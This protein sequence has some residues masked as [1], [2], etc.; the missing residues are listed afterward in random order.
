M[1]RSIQN[2][3][4][5]GLAALLWL[6]AGIS[7]GQDI[8]NSAFTVGTTIRDSSGQGWAYITW[9]APDAE[10]LRNRDFAVYR[11][12]GAAP[13]EKLSIAR[14]TTD[15]AL[16]ET[17]LERSTHVGQDL[18]K[19]GD[20]IDS[21]F[22]DLVTGGPQWTL[23]QK[24]S[25]I[26]SSSLN[27]PEASDHLTMLARVFPAVNLCMGNA[28]IDALND[29]A[30]KTYEIRDFDVAA[31]RDLSVIGQVSLTNGQVVKLTAPGAP[32]AIQDRSP[33]GNL[34]AKL[35]WAT[36]NELRRLGPLT[37]G[38]NVFRFDAQ[39]AETNGYNYVAPDDIDALLISNPTKVKKINRVLAHALVDYSDSDYN[40]I[41]TDLYWTLLGRLPDG[42]GLAYWVGQL[43]AGKTPSW[44]REQISLSDEYRDVWSGTNGVP[45]Q[46]SG[47]NAS[48]TVEG[49]SV[50]SPTDKEFFVADDNGAFE[51][52]GVPFS[53]CDRFYYFVAAVDVLGRNG[54]LSPGSEV[55]ICDQMEP[56]V[57]RGLKVENQYT[58]T[59]NDSQ[60]LKVIWDQVPG[61]G[62]TQVANYYVYRWT[63]PGE[64]LSNALNPRIRPIAGPIAH[65][66][67]AEQNFYVDDKTGSPSMPTFAGTT[68]WY[69]VV[70][71]D[72]AQCGSCLGNRSGHSPP[73]FGVLRDRVGPEPASNF[74]VRI[75]C[76][77]PSVK[78]T[79]TFRIAAA[80]PGSGVQGWLEIPNL[81]ALVTA[82]DACSAVESITQVP[83][84]GTRVG[85]TN[86]QSITVT[87]RDTASN[88]VSRT[89][90]VSVTNTSLPRHDNFRFECERN[91]AGIQWAEFF[92]KQGTNTTLI[93]MG[94]RYFEPDTDK[95]FVT[96]EEMP[97]VATNV[98]VAVL[99]RVG[100]FSG[101][102]TPLSECRYN[103][104]TPPYGTI[105]VIR[106]VATIS[107]SDET[108]SDAC[109]T[110][111]TVD[112]GSTAINPVELRVTPTETTREWKVYRRVDDQPKT[113]VAQGLVTFTNA[114]A[115]DIVWKDSSPPV[116]GGTV[117]YFM[118]LFDEHGNPGPM[119]RLDCITMQAVPGIST[120]A[121]G[122][123]VMPAPML[124]AVDP[125]GS[126][127]SPEM[128]L[129]WFCEPDGVDHFNIWISS[130]PDGLPSPYSDRLS[131]N[132]APPD[133][134]REVTIGDERKLLRFDKFATRR[135]G[136]D[137]I[138]QQPMFFLKIPAELDKS[139]TLAI[140]AVDS[141]G[142][143]SRLSNAQRIQ[144]G[145]TIAAT[146][147]L[148]ANDVPWPARPWRKVTNSGYVNKCVAKQ[149]SIPG[150]G[151]QGVGVRIGEVGI[152]RTACANGSDADPFFLPGPLAPAEHVYF[153]ELDSG[154]R[155]MPFMLYRYQVANPKGLT[156]ASGDIVQVSP[157]MEEIAY[158]PGFS[159]RLG[160]QGNFVK[161][162][163]FAVLP[164]DVD[165]L[166]ETTGL[167]AKQPAC[168]RTLP[169]LSYK[170]IF[171]DCNGPVTKFQDPPA[172]TVMGIGTNPVTI[173]ARDSFGNLSTNAYRTT[174]V[175]PE[176][177]VNTP[178]NHEIYVLDTQPVLVGAK[179]RYLVVLF[180]ALHEIDQ[181]IPVDEVEISPVP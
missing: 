106:F 110:H 158:A 159:Q 172:G 69:T 72:N 160:L 134:R 142:A 161:D 96:Y 128:S 136:S 107:F 45:P 33:K 174:F 100:T 153:S 97:L 122:T 112:P 51:A 80:S 2:V 7:F 144:F 148:A 14:M 102:E 78:Y 16:I 167:Y 90:S 76:D 12:S 164:E 147:G 18:V 85:G 166:D 52:G 42:D 117:C 168:F 94:R 180:N 109:S 55:R 57:P 77:S 59:T 15:P 34:V 70:A 154:K 41:V 10:P 165:V 150:T 125:A 27:D 178:K 62:A 149:I 32:F 6:A 38:F 79:N 4:G 141:S 179:Y 81:A 108:Q 50:T 113:L 61:T 1:K 116:N 133:E 132:L 177:P 130:D 73:G 64:A 53:G 29:G 131:T 83:V 35:R 114:T 82:T 181:V 17:L 23:A 86:S 111:V 175:V 170:A 138:G 40:Q 87:A 74:A 43:N 11:K 84:P 36:P 20:V 68:V 126:D 99:C 92:I 105:Q 151:F 3:T 25:A 37:T 155:I 30:L 120:D 176:P 65:I 171:E 19:L 119:T 89:V 146:N 129:V 56:P 169:D 66:P 115:Q 67:G 152:Q 28:Y 44:V 135:L 95:V 39:F 157:L 58:F 91:A 75:R 121:P 123:D 162:P 60:V 9:S 63:G 143:E 156:R 118:Q 124:S 93:P 26:I 24:M 21:L 71:E 139:Y 163:F 54:S 101:K 145:Q 103:S 98:N 137:Q 31:Q 140:T 127:E 13:F 8:D 48:E 49:A 22:A 5:L 104:G 88:T 47:T 173:T 46:S